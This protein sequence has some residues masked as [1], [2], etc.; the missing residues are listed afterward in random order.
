MCCA[1]ASYQV[2]ETTVSIGHVKSFMSVGKAAITCE[3]ACTCA[4]SIL[5][6]TVDTTAAQLFFHTLVVSQAAGCVLAVTVLPVGA[7]ISSGWPPPPCEELL[8]TP[9]SSA[10]GPYYSSLSNGRA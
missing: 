8:C 10:S 9:S 4:P 2:G 7:C 3:G 6:A 5:D 1:V